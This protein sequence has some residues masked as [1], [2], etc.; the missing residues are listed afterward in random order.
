[1]K[2]IK[3]K[4]QYFPQGFTMI[5]AMVVIAII[6]VIA[7]AVYPSI[8]NTLQVRMLENSAKDVLTTME[9]AKFQAVKTKL[10]HRIRFQQRNT[11]WYFFIEQETALGVWGKMSGFVDKSIPP[12]FNV[13]MS[14][15]NQTVEFSPLG[16]V[17]N[18]VT[19]NN[20]VTLQSNKLLGYNRDDQR[21]INVY[22]GGSIQYVKARSS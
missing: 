18:F 14:L 8:Q 7:L 1:M 5:E 22:A 4:N 3:R 19:A 2:D 21:I 20:S 15:Q 16:L 9:Q 11:I 6:G 13:T 12:Q 17:L 10:N